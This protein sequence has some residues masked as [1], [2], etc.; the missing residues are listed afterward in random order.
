MVGALKV[1][2]PVLG[3]P[4]IDT[5]KNSAHTNMKEGRFSVGNQV[6]RVA[7]AFDTT[8]QAIILC[9]GDKQGKSERL[10]YK[11]L[12]ATADKRFT[13]HIEKLNQQKS[14]ERKPR[15]RK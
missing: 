12:I 14:N 5:L 4:T 1:G 2:G 15:H 6:W 7:L 11:Q 9:A 10:F 3:R 13:D 8:R